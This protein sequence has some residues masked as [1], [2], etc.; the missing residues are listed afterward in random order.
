ML[1]SCGLLWPLPLHLYTHLPGDPAGDTGVYVWNL[2]IFRHEVLRHATFPFWTDHIFSYT[3]GTDFTLHNYTAIAGLLGSPLIGPLGVVATYNLLLLVFVALSG[4]CAFLLARRLGLGAVAA[5]CAGALFMTSPV[6]TARE[7]AHFSLVMAAPL[8][9]FVWALLRALDRKRARD[10]ALVGA[11]VAV[12]FY[13]DAYYGIYCALMG[14]FLVA[15]RFI[16]IELRSDPGRRSTSATIVNALIAAVALVIG[17]RVLTGTPAVSLG[18]IRIGLQTLYTPVLLL[19]VLVALRAW[20]AWRPVPVLNDPSRELRGLWVLG[21]VAVA[22]CVLLILP[23]LAGIALR[24]SEDRLPETVTYWR[25][26]PR[27]LDALAYVVPNPTSSLFGRFTRSWFMPDAPDAFPEF[28]GAISLVALLVIVA[29]WRLRAL[30]TLWVAFTAFFAWL[31][32]GPFLHVAGF[33]TQLI[34]PWALLRYVPVIGM[35]RSPSRFAVVAALGI[36]ILFGYAL[37]ALR[38]RG[39]KI[40]WAAILALAL[41]VELTPAPRRLYSA[42]VPDVYASIAATRDE[43]GRLLELPTG[44]RDGTSSLGNFSAS[45]AYFQTAHRRPLIGGYMSRV[46]SWRR[47]AHQRAPMLRALF[48]LSEGRE[49]SPEWEEAARQSRD[50]FLRRSC[51]RF[52]VLDKHRAS[53]S[54]RRFAVGTLG[55]RLLHEDPDYALFVPDSA[56]PC[57]PPRQGGFFARRSP[58]IDLQ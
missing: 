12:A 1:L 37:D 53:E 35:A 33:N 16:R 3:G 28:V 7:S 9:L 31:S 26:S 54:L 22:V 15:W 2:W 13:S 18:P 32:L 56:P 17:W 50:R 20:L 38:G 42:A 51:V 47:R 45:A 23:V 36:A 40:R 39:M 52:V 24:Y 55:L 34:G 10:A 44:V 11:L 25:T 8:P 19:T 21:A 27:G 4:L 58:A 6:L 43:S 41:A 30:P 57:D 49:I 5:W 29:G 14:A 48:A 46:S